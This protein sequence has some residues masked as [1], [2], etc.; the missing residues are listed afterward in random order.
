MLGIWARE[1]FRQKYASNSL[2]NAPVNSRKDHYLGDGWHRHGSGAFTGPSFRGTRAADRVERPWLAS[3]WMELACSPRRQTR[4][5]S[6]NSLS[7]SGL[8]L[9][10]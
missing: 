2:K 5:R 4:P 9:F 8:A 3:R 1:P 7:S 10:C 6:G